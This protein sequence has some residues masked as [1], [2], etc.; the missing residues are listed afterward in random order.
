MSG[1][2]RE[3]DR[4]A[5]VMHDLSMVRKCI[6]ERAVNHVSKNPR[7]LA[8]AVQVRARKSQIALWVWLRRK[9]AKARG[10]LQGE[11]VSHV[12]ARNIP[13]DG[14]K[15]WLAQ[16]VLG[17]LVLLLIPLQQGLAADVVGSALACAVDHDLDAHVGGQPC[18]SAA[19]L[20]ALGR[21]RRKSWG[22]WE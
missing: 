9:T 19:S 13:D 12:P 18:K 15:P 7:H 2:V 3:R 14:V 11:E 4:I 21:P 16:R 10:I 5:D 6:Q 17:V 8:R 20:G 22:N 1:H